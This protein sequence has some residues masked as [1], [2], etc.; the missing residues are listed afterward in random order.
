[1]PSDAPVKAL[2]C[3]LSASHIFQPRMDADQA[4]IVSAYASKAICHAGKANLM[5]ARGTATRYPVN[6]LSSGS[7]CGI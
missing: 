1:V 7:S 5:N 3:T 2:N 4:T 6:D